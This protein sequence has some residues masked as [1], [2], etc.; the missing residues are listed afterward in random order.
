MEENE[1]LELTNE[2]ENVETE[3]TEEMMDGIELTDTITN[4]ETQEVEKEEAKKTLREIL[5]E[6]PEYQ[7]EFDGMVKK[8]LDRQDKNYQKE[9]SKYK[10]TENVLRATL[11]VSEGE[12]VNQKLRESYEADGIKLPSRYEPGLS[13]REIELL[14][15]GEAADIIEDG[16]DAAV[17]EANRLAAKKYENLNERERIVF[18]KLAEHLNIENDKRELLK[19]GAKEELLSDK[20]FNDF[21]KKFNS[22]VSIKD[23]YSL[24]KNVQPK[25]EVE[26]PGSLKSTNSKST[27]KDFYTP[28]E[29][30]KFTRADYDK[31]PK[32]LEAVEN[33]M[34]LWRKNN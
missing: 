6:N 34:T 20:S 3:T 5:K 14:A 25:K 29:A 1:M 24:Y 9:L 10:D 13:S 23:I 27:I 22:N 8:R 28:E 32:L 33:S 21:R 12:D 15:N 31:N 19:L 26:N 18:N 7:E 4:E 17:S 16:Y 11:N 30:S 2:T